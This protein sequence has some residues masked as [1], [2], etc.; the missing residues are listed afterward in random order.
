MGTGESGEFNN[1][2]ACVTNDETSVEFS[3]GVSI[4]L[5]YE[6]LFVVSQWNPVVVEHMQINRKLIT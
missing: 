5:K 3:T 2:K 6:T 1:T 4:I